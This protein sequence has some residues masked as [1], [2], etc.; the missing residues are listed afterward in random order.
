MRDVIH[1]ALKK[2]TNAHVEIRIEEKT[3][4]SVRFKDR[5]IEEVSLNTSRG[6]SIRA[7]VG[8]G[9]GFVSFNDINNLDKKVDLAINQAMII[10]T[11]SL[12]FSDRPPVEHIGS[13][14]LENDATVVPLHVKTQVLSLIHI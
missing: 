14:D 9:W 3:T 2:R 7:L 4:T 12:R 6:G 8:G 1:E 10:N 5:E 13:S 11:E